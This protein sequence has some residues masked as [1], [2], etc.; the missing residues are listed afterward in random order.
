VSRPPRLVDVARVDLPIEEASGAAVR[1]TA[2]GAWV[3]IVGDRTAAVAVAPIG[4]SGPG[5]WQVIDL[6]PAL[7]GA[8]DPHDSQLEAVAVDGVA[9]LALMREDPPTVWLLHEQER[10]LLAT[11]TLTVPDRSPVAASWARHANSR[12][13]GLVLLRDGRLLVAK[14]K[15]PAALVEFGPAGAAP[16]GV[17]PDRLLAPGESFA[18]P[19]GAVTYEALAAW[20]LVGDAAEAL[21]DVSDLG[22]TADGA[23]WLLSDASGCVA[24]VELD[25]PLAPEGGT[26]ATLAAVLRVPAG[27]RKAEG[28]ARLTDELVL[29]VSDQ[30]RGDGAAVL[31]RI[32]EGVASATTTRTEDA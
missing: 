31:C 27:V 23:L 8:V 24:R 29:V 19:A 16:L 7:A 28:A 4:E 14:E 32:P 20:P 15:K 30:R 10:R 2:N 18:A 6:A 13:E 12:G 9:T 3:L 21:E 5:P 17:A 11:I 1:R 25:P 26:I 22:V